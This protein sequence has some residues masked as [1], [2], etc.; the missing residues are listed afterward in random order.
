MHKLNEKAEGES[1]RVTLRMDAECLRIINRIAR[2]IAKDGGGTCDKSRAIRAIVRAHAQS[3]HPAQDG[4]ALAKERD[5]A[6]RERDALAAV[7]DQVV[8][9]RDEAREALRLA[10][11]ALDALRASAPKVVAHKPVS[12]PVEPT[13]DAVHNATLRARWT[14]LK[15]PLRPFVARHDITRTPFQK[16]CA[17]ERDMHG[18]T[19]GKYEAAIAAEEAAK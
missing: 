10:Q 17:G 5:D 11:E 16:W 1:P 18:E 9:E 14:A 3:T 8:K 12:A 15:V 2:Q 7:R 6:A 13:D 4:F 19:L